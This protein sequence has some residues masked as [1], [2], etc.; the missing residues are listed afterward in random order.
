LGVYDFAAGMSGAIERDQRAAAEAERVR[1]EQERRAA[2]ERERA[3][4]RERQAEIARREGQERLRVAERFQDLA[5]KREAGAYGYGDR[6]VRWQAAPENLRKVVED[7][8]GVP[9]QA[10]AIFLERLRS[11]PAAARAIGQALDHQE[12]VLE[13]VMEMR[14]DRGIS[15]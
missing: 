13:R 4:E 7:Y 10:K 3:A 11:E 15:M 2:L 8:N 5:S 6:D 14:M 9:Q 12:R 1:Q